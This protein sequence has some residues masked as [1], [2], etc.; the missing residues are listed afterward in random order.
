MLVVTASRRDPRVAAVQGITLWTG[1]SPY[2]AGTCKLVRVP[3]LVT[4]S[5]P[6]LCPILALGFGSLGPSSLWIPFRQRAL[7]PATLVSCPSLVATP[8]FVPNRCWPRSPQGGLFFAFVRKLGQHY[9]ASPRGASMRP[10]TAMAGDDARS[11]SET[12]A[13]SLGSISR[14][15][16]TR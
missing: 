9:G 1:A 6:R 15:R 16:R 14:C 4:T 10:E 8:A 7:G 13:A 12:S 3:R 2:A 5:F 11:Q